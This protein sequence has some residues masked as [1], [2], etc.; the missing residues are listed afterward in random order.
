[1][2]NEPNST[3]IQLGVKLRDVRVALGQTK[4]LAQRYRGQLPEGRS[5][6]DAEITKFLNGIFFFETLL[7]DLESESHGGAL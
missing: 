3:P 2:S 1:M 6:R 4:L 5:R 7:A